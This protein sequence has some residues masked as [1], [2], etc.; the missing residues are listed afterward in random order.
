MKYPQVNLFPSN[1][2]KGVEKTIFVIICSSNKNKYSYI[3]LPFSSKILYFVN[4]SSISSNVNP[5]GK[6]LKISTA[7]FL[8][9]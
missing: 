1:K 4:N 9:T 6:S 8:S 3:Y 5:I 2:F 7:S